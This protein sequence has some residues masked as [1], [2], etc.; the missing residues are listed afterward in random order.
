MKDKISVIVP[1]YNVE[2]YLKRCIESLLNQSYTDLEILLVDDGSPDN[3]GMI[4]DEY[5]QKDS[6][7]RVFHKTNG[8]V[9]S[10]RN[11][12]LKEATGKYVSFVD[13]D[14]YVAPEYLERMYVVLKKSGSQLAVCKAFDCN[15]STQAYFN[16]QPKSYQNVEIVAVDENYDFLAKYSKTC[17]WGVLYDTAV[18][19]NLTFPDDLYVGEDTVFF[20]Q[21]L[22]NCKQIVSIQ[23]QLYCYVLNQNSVTAYTAYTDKKFTEVEAWRRVCSLVEPMGGII[24]NSARACYMLN[25]TKALKYMSLFGGRDKKKYDFCVME[26]RKTISCLWHSSVSLISK[27]GTTLIAIF[28]GGGYADLHFTQENKKIIVFFCMQSKGCILCAA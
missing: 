26:A 7:V 11:L 25:C 14:D 12:A 28:P 18:I 23:D 2:K 4:C 3:C 8:G 22:L 20:A 1:I 13:P 9:A 19:K 24:Y 15:E 5:G 27:I 6:R 16:M 17:A 10:A 21:A